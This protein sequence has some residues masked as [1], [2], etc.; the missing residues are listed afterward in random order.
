MS[1]KTKLNSET[2]SPKGLA[3]AACSPH[4]WL[5]GWERARKIY[6][7][8]GSDD[9]DGNYE[10]SEKERKAFDRHKLARKK[11]WV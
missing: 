2:T 5:R 11:V 4:F 10:P 8:T 9:G 3:T 7:W 1:K 6:D